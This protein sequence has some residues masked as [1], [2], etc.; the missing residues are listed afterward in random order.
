M[1][2]GQNKIVSVL[3][4]IITPFTLQTN[5]TRQILANN[6]VRRL[7]RILVHLI[8]KERVKVLDEYNKKLKYSGYIKQD[9]VKI[10]GDGL[11]KHIQK[12]GSK[13]RKGERGFRSAEETDMERREKKLMEKAKWF[14][15]KPDIQEDSYPALRKNS[16]RAASRERNKFET[17][18][19]FFVKCTPGS[20]SLVEEVMREL[21]TE[22]QDVSKFLKQLTS[23]FDS[24]QRN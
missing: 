24:N 2:E 4:Y 9:R 17:K 14:I 13:R 12:M 1:M 20:N 18:T 8:E 11:S 16:S 7:D 21:H 19:V 6:A 5:S 23:L 10:L 22:E 15:E 3:D